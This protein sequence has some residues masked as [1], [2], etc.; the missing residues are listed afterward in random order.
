MRARRLLKFLA[1]SAWLLAG[2]A[3]AQ[4]AAGNGT[5]LPP[6]HGDAP[7]LSV[8][9]QV[10]Q[11]PRAVPIPTLAADSV[12]APLPATRDQLASR[13]RLL[14]S[15]NDGRVANGS[16]RESGLEAGDEVYR[17]GDTLAVVRLS[18]LSREFFWLEGPV[19]LQ[20]VQFVPEPGGHYR[21]NA[22]INPQAPVAHR[23]SAAELHRVVNAEVPA[24]GS[25]ERAR[26]QRLC[27]NGKTIA[28]T[29]RPGGLLPADRLLLGQKAVVMV[30]REGNDMARYWLKGRIDLGQGGLQKVDGNV[31]EVIGVVH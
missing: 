29:I 8:I 25:A 24:A 6:A 19:D 30:R 2:A 12:A 16:L 21:V 28:A 10:A 31:Y 27:N 13:Q 26:L 5:R 20:R 1:W 17:D 18:G 23:I 14:E 9:P 22:S 4:E 11:A 7:Q 15:L 3:P